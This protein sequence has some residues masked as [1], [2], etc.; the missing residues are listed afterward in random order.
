[1]FVIAMLVMALMIIAVAGSSNA[2]AK[3]KELEKVYQDKWCSA[4]HG[5]VEAKFPGEDVRCDCLTADY[6]VEFDFAPKWAESVGQAL[7]YATLSGKKATVVLIMEHPAD[8][9]YVER[10][11][12]LIKYHHLNVEVLTIENY[13]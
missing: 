5:T 7:Y 1:M 12:R 3:H 10:V 6:A 8:K 4:H 13:K 11:E 2:N 9:I